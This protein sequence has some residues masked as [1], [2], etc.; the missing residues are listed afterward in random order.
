MKFSSL[1]VFSSFPQILPDIK[2]ILV[3]PILKKKMEVI[4]LSIFSLASIQ[5]SILFLPFFFSAGLAQF[6]KKSFMLPDS[7]STLLFSKCNLD[8]SLTAVLRCLQWYAVAKF[9]DFVCLG[10][11]DLSGV[12]DIVDY[13]FFF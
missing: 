3:S 11:V 5:Y 6:L 4:L 13:L 12:L 10:S 1:F 7:T 9:S 8:S 2:H